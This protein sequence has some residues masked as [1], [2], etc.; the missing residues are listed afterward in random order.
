MLAVPSAIAC[1]QGGRID[2]ARRFLARAELSA[3][4]WEGTAWQAAMTEARACIAAAEGDEESAA[5]FMADA[6][7]LF[8]TVGQPLDAARCR[9]AVAG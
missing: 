9:E 3:A 8:A 2:G 1:A 6:A 7:R 4:L 5:R